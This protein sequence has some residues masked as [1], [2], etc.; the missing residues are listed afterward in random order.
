MV[1]IGQLRERV[2]IQEKTTTPDSQGGRTT[3]WGTLA[4]VWASV[5]PLTMGEKLQASAVGSTLAYR[6]TCRY[7]ADVTPAMRIT[8]MPFMSETTKTLE[9]HG[10]QAADGGR[11]W[12]T[13]DCA[14]VI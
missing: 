13:M 10:V 9:I 6:V 8:W 3:T 2:T 1:S 14:E 4:T 12:L 5:V 11:Q 7:R